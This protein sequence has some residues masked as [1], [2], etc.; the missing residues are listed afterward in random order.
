MLEQAAIIAQA[1]RQIKASR[2]QMRPLQKNNLVIII[3]A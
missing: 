1:S 3:S 2:R